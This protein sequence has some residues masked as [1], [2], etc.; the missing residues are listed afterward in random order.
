MCTS[1][2]GLMENDNFLD[3]LVTGDKK[4]ILNNNV[5]KKHIWVDC[6]QPSLPTAKAGLHLKKICCVFGGVSRA[7]FIMSC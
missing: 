1:L 6:R 2:L 4:W 5:Q 7:Y 3:C